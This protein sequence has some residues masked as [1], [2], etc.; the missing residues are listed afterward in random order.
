MRPHEKTN[1]SGKKVKGIYDIT[2]CVTISSYINYYNIY[3]SSIY[4]KKKKKKK[5]KFSLVGEPF[6]RDKDWRTNRCAR[7]RYK[8]DDESNHETL[9]YNHKM[10]ELK[11][12]PNSIIE[13]IQ[14]WALIE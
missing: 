6:V 2:I 9:K 10:H 1:M 8:W 4:L 14:N 12:A 5:R 11:I 7:I 13:L 3:T